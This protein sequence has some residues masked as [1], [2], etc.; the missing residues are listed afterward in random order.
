MT[1]MPRLRD[2]KFKGQN[3]KKRSESIF[4]KSLCVMIG[5]ESDKVLCTTMLSTCMFFAD[6]LG[7]EGERDLGSPAPAL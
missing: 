4:D 7:D 3:I 6:S 2:G 5:F 1:T